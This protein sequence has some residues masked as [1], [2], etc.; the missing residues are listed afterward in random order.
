MNKIGVN[1]SDHFGMNADD[2]CR[3]FSQIGFDAFF[4]EYHDTKQTQSFAEAAQTHDLFFESLHAPFDGINNIWLDNEAGEDMLRRLINGID[5]CVVAGAPICVVHLSSG[6][7]PPSITD[8]GRMRFA[9]LVEYAQQKNIRIAFE[10]QRK[11]ANLAWAFETFTDDN[12]VGFCW[13]CGHESCFTFGREYMPLFGTR[14]LCTHIH[15]NEGVFD[16]DDHWIPFDGN[17]NFDRF[18]EHIRGSNYHG[19]LMLEL[20]YN[21]PRYADMPAEIYLRR[22][23]DAAKRLVQMVDE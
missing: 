1:H 8:I 13:D 20:A 22:A 10:N 21:R 14:L 3:L 16:K 5:M 7:T 23:A 9:K 15:D 19:S 11:L 2:S 18:A 6:M 17:I 4:V 12:V